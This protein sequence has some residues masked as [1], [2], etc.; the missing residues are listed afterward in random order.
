[1]LLILYFFIPNGIKKIQNSADSEY[2]TKERKFYLHVCEN[3]AKFVHV[4][5]VARVPFQELH[6]E[7]GVV[8][9]YNTDNAASN[10]FLAL[11]TLQH[12]GQQGC[13]IA[14]VLPDGSIGLHKGAGLVKDV[15]TAL[16]QEM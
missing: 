13:G 4:S 10:A 12:R 11:Q 9:F 2:V 16:Y 8:G 5:S 15:F 6:E 3:I 14:A 7:C 1:M